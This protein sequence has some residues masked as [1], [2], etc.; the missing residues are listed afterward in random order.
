MLTPPG[1]SQ[2]ALFP[3]VASI[4][5]A[6]QLG[7]SVLASTQGERWHATGA[8]NKVIHAMNSVGPAVLVMDGDKSERIVD[9]V[10]PGNRVPGR[11]EFV[12][13]NRPHELVQVALAPQE[14]G[15]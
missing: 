13:R 12:V 6:R 11:G 5:S 10:R 2:S 8:M 1:T 14:V 7:F 9:G 15:R 4:E 3:L